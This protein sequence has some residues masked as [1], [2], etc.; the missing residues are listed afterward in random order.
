MLYSTFYISKFAINKN[1]IFDGN[2]NNSKERKNNP[3]G[4]TVVPPI[5]PD[6]PEKEIHPEEEVP[7]K[8]IP[9]EEINPKNIPEIELPNEDEVPKFTDYQIKKIH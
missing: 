7:N 5:I 1:L 3:T 4:S 2:D 8:T 9:E 6:I